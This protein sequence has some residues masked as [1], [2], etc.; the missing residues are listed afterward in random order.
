MNKKVVISAKPSSYPSN[1]IDKWVQGEEIKQN[2]QSHPEKEVR[3]TVVI[4]E[5]LHFR[6]K[7]KAVN[8]RLKLKGV[9][10]KIIENYVNSNEFG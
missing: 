8:E 7:V 1:D 6:L 2:A 9:I 5:K 10:T 3:F 4:P